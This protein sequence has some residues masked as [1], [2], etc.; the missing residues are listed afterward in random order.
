MVLM[1]QQS[2]REWLCYGDENTRLF[3]AKVKQRKLATYIYTIK[4]ENEGMVEGFKEEGS[5]CTITTK[6]TTGNQCISRE[7]IK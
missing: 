3:S 5:S 2:K 1:K 4:K 6:K 7:G